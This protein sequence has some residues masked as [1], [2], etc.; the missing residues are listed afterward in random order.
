MAQAAINP[1]DVEAFGHARCKRRKIAR[2]LRLGRF[3]PIAAR[4]SV[5]NSRTQYTLIQPAR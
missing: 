1:E 5:E 2:N 3:L 4:T